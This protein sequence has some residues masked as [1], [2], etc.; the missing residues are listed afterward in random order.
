MNARWTAGLKWGVV[1]GVMLVWGCQE[2]ACPQSAVVDMPS[3]EFAPAV[4]SRW[5]EELDGTDVDDAS[6]GSFPHGAIDGGEPED[7]DLPAGESLP[8]ARLDID[9]EQGIVVRSYVDDDGRTVEERWR[10]REGV[11]P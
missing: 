9:T 1:T 5:V 6:P 7:E 8:T 3:G 4:L 10:F 11:T 2:F